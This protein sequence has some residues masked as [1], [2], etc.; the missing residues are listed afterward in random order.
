MR[1]TWKFVVAFLFLYSCVLLAQQLEIH[2]INVGQGDATLIISPTGKTMLI[3]AGNT[4]YGTAVVSAYLSL[5]SITSLNYVV[6]SHYHADHLGGLDEVMNNLGVTNIG[7]VY[8]RGR[9]TPLPTSLAFRDYE[10]VANATNNRHTVMLGETLDLGG[11]VTMKCL[12]TNG[13]VI[14]YGSVSGASGSE[15]DLSLGWLLTYNGFQYFTGGDLGG[16]TSPY[17]DNETPLATQ[18][19]DVDVM[20]ID[21]HGSHF[22]T[23]QTFVNNLKP[24]VAIIEVGDNNSYNHPTQVVLDRLAAVNCFIYQT[25]L[26]SGGTIPSGAGVVTN[27]NVIIKTLGTGYTVTYGS[28]VDSYPGDNTVIVEPEGDVIPA[29]FSLYQNFPNPF[30]LTTTIKFDLPEEKEIQLKVY[31]IFGKEVAELVNE[32]KPAGRYKVEFNASSLASGIY[33]CSIHTGSFGDVKIMILV[34]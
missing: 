6:C 5:L 32:N 28:T 9:D 19:G 23:N 34:K 3:D 18:V 8:D 30:N 4:S 25:E 21:H 14:N 24:E 27:G 22:S 16:E 33:Y 11:G 1:H 26:G 7:A 29:A 2:H 15:N 13:E 20:K 17:A 12:A 31:D 10:T